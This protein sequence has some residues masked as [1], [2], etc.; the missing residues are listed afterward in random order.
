MAALGT[1]VAVDHLSLL[2]K[3]S[4]AGS[5]CRVLFVGSYVVGFGRAALA[6]SPTVSADI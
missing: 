5:W 6:V 3:P 4:T 2:F 1:S